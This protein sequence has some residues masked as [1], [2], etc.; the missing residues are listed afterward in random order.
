MQAAASRPRQ[1]ADRGPR[2]SQHAARPAWAAVPPAA[3]ASDKALGTRRPG[4]PPERLASGPRPSLGLAGAGP[5]RLLRRGDLGDPE[6]ELL[7][8]RNDLAAGDPVPVDE[9]VDG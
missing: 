5:Q 8:D 2:R 6:A 1:V 3:A 7:V 4:C 9:E